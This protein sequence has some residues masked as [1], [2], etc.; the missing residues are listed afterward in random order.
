MNHHK[1]RGLLLACVMCACVLGAELQGL[2]GNRVFGTMA[3]QTSDGEPVWDAIWGGAFD[4]EFAAI[5]SDN[6]SLYVCGTS[7]SYTPEPNMVLLKRNATTG[8][9]LWYK[10]WDGGDRTVGLGIWG[11]DGFIYTSGY[12]ES[13]DGNAFLVKWY[14]TNGSMIWNKTWGISQNSEGAGE[15]WGIEGYIYVSGSIQSLNNLTNINMT[16]WKFYAANG[17]MIWAKSPSFSSED[18]GGIITGCSSYLLTAGYLYNEST[19][20]D[21]CLL[22]KWDLDGNIFW[23]ATYTSSGNSFIGGAW[24]E[25]SDVFTISH[26]VGL[27]RAIVSKWN[28]TTGVRLLPFSM[29]Q[30]WGEGQGVFGVTGSIYTLSTRGDL[31]ISKWNPDTCTPV[32]NTTWGGSYEWGGG[33]WVTENAIFAVGYTESGSTSRNAV[34]LKCHL[35]G[36]LYPMDS[37]GDGMPDDWEQTNGLSMFVPDD[38]G[39]E[40]YDDLT[41]LEEYQHDTDPNDY[42][43]DDDGLYDYDEC[44]LFGSNAT[45]NDTDNDGLPDGWEVQEGTSLLVNDS[46]ADPDLDGLS[47]FGEFQNGTKPL[48]NDTDG[49]AMPD[50]WEE[51]HALNP[52]ANDSALDPDHDGLTNLQE[53]LH[54]GNP[55]SVDS[56]GDGLPDKWEA[57]YGLDLQVNDAELDPDADGL[58]NKQEYSYLTN[59]HNPDTD[60]DGYS[61]SAEV[62]GQTDPLDPNSHPAGT[63]PVPEAITITCITVAV[64]AM[65]AVGLERQF[66]RKPRVP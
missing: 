56:D 65:L 43:S 50:G 39:D 35:N 47:N 61:D 44:I 23:N 42:D 34:M 25:G 20:R 33:I 4:D 14:G 5:W 12:T 55:H 15:I 62:T 1:L 24:C 58:D 38:N 54:D 36:T 21:D 48:D 59:P 29:T 17:S 31:R 52:L 28:A 16:L 57:D 26:D 3:V 8:D 11:G 63:I 13:P 66:R 40:D 46:A 45:N 9:V 19:T 53:F 2:G 18:A 64:V 22:V 27:S 60:G 32:W 49:D 51:L 7:M 41:N 6:E 30:E 37:D 10:F